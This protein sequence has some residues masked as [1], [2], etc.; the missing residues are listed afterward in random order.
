MKKLNLLFTVLLG[1]LLS[2]SLMTESN[3]QP[4][5]YVANA[6]TNNVSV[7]NVATNTVTA[8][9]PVGT[10]PFYLA[11]TPVGGYVYVT[12][13]YSNDVSVINTA[14]NSLTTTIPV[15]NNPSGV[16]FTPDGAFAYVVN[17]DFL[18]TGSSTVSVINT[19]TNSVTT[20]I[21]VGNT[22]YG[23]A[24]TPDGGF[25][26]VVNRGSNNV[27][28]INTSTNSVTA[29]L[30]VGNHPLDVAIT[31]DGAFAYVTNTDANTVSVINT[32]TNTI[33][34]TIPVGYEPFGVAITPDGSNIYVSNISATVSVI[35]ASTNSVTVTIP[36]G[37][38]L[39]EIAISPDGS[40]AYVT[41]GDL[42]KVSVINTSTNSVITSIAV[43]V[44][45]Y[46]IAF[47]PIIQT[48]KD[49]IEALIEQVEGLGLQQGIE[50]SLTSKLENAIDSLE[51]GNT[52]GAIIKL[53]DFI[54]EV[55]AQSGK[56]IDEA[57]AD[58]LIAAAQAIID[59][60]QSSLPKKGNQQT[61]TSSD[62]K[63]QSYSLDQNYPNP[64]NPTTVIRYSLPEN[65]RVNLVVYDILGRQ[66]AELV[67]GEV[68]AGYHQVEFNASRL[69]SGIY[70]YRLTAD[71]FTQ[72]NKML[73]MK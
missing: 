18:N 9:V 73:L 4:Y 62:I 41:N 37:G 16:A 5:A 34:T 43:G 39:G 27:S 2:I 12:N 35:A 61:L 67:N 23:V 1:C 50:N 42:N 63:P 15:G 28:V 53:N 17:Y 65:A 33:T 40:L 45:P 10:T 13:F 52:A 55:Q 29:T 51:N 49:D 47:A 21:S 66:V 70:F 31:P 44:S 6:G 7:I 11:T 30:T 59:E 22:P 24:I 72:I 14:T 71:K 68:G 26:Y 69:A 36:V 25:A 8:T 20:T 58:D 32:A 48:P 3:A 60:L 19:A 38:V 64:F 57:D 56:K 54:N 46:Y